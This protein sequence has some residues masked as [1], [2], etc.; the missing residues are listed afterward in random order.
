MESHGE[1]IPDQELLA[2]RAAMYASFVRWSTWSIVGIAL[3]LIGMA[4][5][6]L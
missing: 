4:L 2:T 5:F 1:R 3:L 6:L